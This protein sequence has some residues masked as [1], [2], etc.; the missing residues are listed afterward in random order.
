M[1]QGQRG[2]DRGSRR[3]SRNSL[4]SR[5]HAN[6]MPIDKDIDGLDMPLAP[7]PRGGARRRAASPVQVLCGEGWRRRWEGCDEGRW[8]LTDGCW[9]GIRRFACLRTCCQGVGQ[10]FSQCVSQG[11][12]VF[13][14]GGRGVA[15]EPQDGGGGGGFRKWAPK[16][17]SQF[18]FVCFYP[19]LMGGNTFLKKV[20]APHLYSK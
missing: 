14:L 3:D 12:L 13:A 19:L 11:G 10:T 2:R 16:S 15:R 7:D 4:L 9:G 18:F 6:S 20:S 8:R 1:Y 5:A 17:K